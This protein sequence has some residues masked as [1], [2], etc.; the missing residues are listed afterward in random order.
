MATYH[1]AKSQNI[2][3]TSKTIYYQGD[4]KWTTEM[5]DRKTGT[6]STTATSELYSFGGAVITE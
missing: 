5:S 4:K 2:Q 6:N 3:G 1:I